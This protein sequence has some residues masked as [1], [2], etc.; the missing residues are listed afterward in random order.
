M[1]GNP[2]SDSY[3]VTPRSIR[4][5]NDHLKAI[6]TLTLLISDIIMLVVAFVFSYKAREVLPFFPR[7]EEQ[8]PLIT[9]LPTIILHSATVI[10]MFYFSQLY[11]LKRA[12]SRIDQLRRVVG[13]VT[14]GTLLASGS[15][16]FLLQNTT[17]YTLYPRSLLFY[18]WFFTLILMVAGRELHRRF[19]TLMRRRGII[20]DNLLIVGEGDIAH[21]ITDHVR[22][23]PELGYQIVGI[24][25]A[26]EKQGDLL[27]YPYIGAYYDI[28]RLI[29]DQQVE[30]VIVA[31]SDYRRGELVDLINL[32]QRGKVDIKVYPDLFSYMAGDLN[33]DDLGGTPLLTV[34]DIALRGWKLSLKRALDLFGATVGLILLSPFMLVTALLIRLESS[35]SAFYWQ[36]RMGLD[37]RPFPMIKFRS[38]RQD[39]ESSGRTWTVEN[40]E[41]VTR[42]GH[43]MR[44]S[45]WD[46]IPQLINVLLGHMSLVGPR[47]ERPMYVQ[48]FRRQIPDYMMRHR[49]KS[50]MTGWAQINGLRG[51]TS[52]AQRTE[53]DRFYVENWS[54][55]LDI[56]IIIRTIWQS[57][58]RSN[59]NAY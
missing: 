36:T 10:L 41:R 7:P 17:L 34:R 20:R 21:K 22:T 42:L 55:W 12:V 33:V 50:G 26:E 43:Y 53:A 59:P 49:E 9:Y 58:T 5:S 31:L 38:M 56:V 23:S 39:A 29:D 18:V 46:E 44:R 28:P 15:Q 27:G 1:A 52:I 25:T 8:P 30:Q 2:Q 51:D 6:S 45:N 3:T 14:L 54:F 16:E 11:H 57:I 37:G 32:C 4:L 19:W 40:D 13:V 35:G 24:V 47:P 48:Q